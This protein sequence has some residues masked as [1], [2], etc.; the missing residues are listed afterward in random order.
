MVM[1]D[2]TGAAFE[3]D[4]EEVHMYLVKFISGNNTF[5]SKVQSNDRHSNGRLNY[6]TLK[7][8]YEGVGVNTKYILRAE[9]LLE[10]L[11]YT[12]EKHPHM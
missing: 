9:S 3:I 6:I 5:E 12:G 2:L 11:T 1:A 8:H 10:N 7:E 4:S